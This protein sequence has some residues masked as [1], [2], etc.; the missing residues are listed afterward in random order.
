M[1][2]ALTLGS[3]NRQSVERAVAEAIKILA[4]DGGFILAAI[5]ELFEDSR[6]E[7]IVAMIETWRRLS[8]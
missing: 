1:N 8:P 7:N 4:P 2:S 3:E 6:W 5:D